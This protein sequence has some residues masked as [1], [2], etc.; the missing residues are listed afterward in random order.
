MSNQNTRIIAY[1]GSFD[2]ITMGH[3]SLV[4]RA[5]AIFDQ[6]VVSVVSIPAKPMTFSLDERMDMAR[7]VFAGEPRVSVE[8]FDGLLPKYVR[9]CRADAVLRGL[10]AVSD[11]D[12]EFQLALM[13]RRQDHHV[14]TLFLMTDSQWLYTSSSGIKDLAR[15]GGNITGL[16]PDCV[17][18]RLDEK[19]HHCPQAAS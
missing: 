15:L 13:N 12:C 5:L 6:V 7:E 14:E 11:F 8:G 9:Q 16:V 1:P 2:P 3:V 18:R 4:Q 17:A 19:F 10:R